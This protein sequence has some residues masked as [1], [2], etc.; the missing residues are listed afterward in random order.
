MERYFADNVVELTHKNKAQP[1][2]FYCIED[3]WMAWNAAK[4]AYEWGYTNVMWFREGLDGWKD[5]NGPLTDSE[6][7][8]LPVND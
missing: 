1:F 8:N 7:V 3:C 4:R 2:V 6:P 5:I